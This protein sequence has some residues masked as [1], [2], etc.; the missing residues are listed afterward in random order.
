[1]WEQNY[2][3]F[4]C[5]LHFNNIETAFLSAAALRC[6]IDASTQSKIF[7]LIFYIISVIC[8]WFISQHS[9]KSVPEVFCKKPTIKKANLYRV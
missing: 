1:M 8:F 5:G 6:H 3:W 4:I 9:R 2:F 7:H